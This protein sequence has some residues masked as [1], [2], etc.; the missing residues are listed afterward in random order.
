ML[1]EFDKS[2]DEK[3]QAM[4]IIKAIEQLEEEKKA[5]QE[6]QKCLLESEKRLLDAANNNPHVGEILTST[7]RKLSDYLSTESFKSMD[8]LVLRPVNESSVLRNDAKRKRRKDDVGKLLILYLI[9]MK[10]CHH[11]LLL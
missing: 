6:R 7:K 10:T 1:Q 8:S 5:I 3:E 9:I 2:N 4:D 11:K